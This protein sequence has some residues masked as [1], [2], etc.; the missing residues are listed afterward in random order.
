LL[1]KTFRSSTGLRRLACSASVEWM[2]EDL[3]KCCMW[4]VRSS[5]IDMISNMTL[6]HEIALPISV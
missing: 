6:K 2:K 5:V 4:S 1:I 3:K